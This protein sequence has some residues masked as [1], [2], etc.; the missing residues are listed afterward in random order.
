MKTVVTGNLAS[1]II[2][3]KQKKNYGSNKDCE[4]LKSAP[5][6]NESCWST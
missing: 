1:E 3:E 4:K 2:V 6:K 5:E